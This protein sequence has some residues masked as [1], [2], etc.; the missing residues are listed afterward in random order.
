MNPIKKALQKVKGEVYTDRP[1]L[2]CYST[3]ASIYQIQP[4]AVVCPIK[5]S[6]VS[7]CIAAAKRLMMPVTARAAGTNLAGSCL[8]RGIVLDVSKNMNRIIGVRET[9]RGQFVVE[10]EPGVIINDLQ[11][12]LK[13]KGLFLPHDPSSSEICMIGGN[14][15]TKASGAR[16]VKYG[17]IDDYIESVEF[18]TAEGEIIDTASEDTIPDRIR[19]GISELLERLLAD[20]ATIARLESKRAVKT[21]SGYNMRALLD[22][23]DH[24]RIGC[25]IA[26]LMSGSV[27]TLGIFTRI[28]LK[29]LPIVSGT[30]IS[31][32]YFKSLSDAGDAVQHIRKLGPV[33]IEM[34][35]ATSLGIVRG[36]YPDLEIPEDASALFVEFEGD[37][38][39]S[40]I[41]DLEWMIHERYDVHWI[42][43][44][45]DDQELQEGIWAVRK[46]LVPILTNYDEKIKPDAFIDD[47]AVAIPDLAPLI[48]DLHEI[49]DHYHIAAAIYGHA[50]SGNLHIRPML[51][52]NDPANIKL[53]PELADRVYEAVFKY[54]GT[55]TGE[56]G[57]G[58][59]RTMFLEK[60]WGSEIYG[61]MRE[62]KEI[63]DPNDILNPD[64]IFSERTITEDIK[65]PTKYINKFEARC[66]NCGYCKSVCPIATTK[67]GE[68]GSRSFLQLA[69]FRNFEDPAPG[70]SRRAEKMLRTCLGC[71]R[72]MTRC[73]SH[74]SI[75]E[76]LFS[77]KSPP[78]YTKKAMSMW[79]SDYDRF[80]K[81]A[82]FFGRLMSPA[83]GAALGRDLPKVRK[84]PR[85]FVDRA[86]KQKSGAMTSV[87][88]VAVFEG[89]ASAILDDNVFESMVRVLEESGFDV[90][91]PDQCCCGL[92]MIGEGLYDLARDAARKNVAA[93]SDA[94]YDA[95]VTACASCT[96]ML[97]QFG[98]LLGD[99]SAKKVSSIT[100]DIGEFLEKFTDDRAFSKEKLEMRVA[101]HHP[102][103]LA[104]AGVADADSCAILKRIVTD[105]V[106]LPDGCCGGAGAYGILH[107]D[108]SERIFDRKAE[109]I[110]EI[111]P[112]T[113]VTTCPSCELQFRHN[114]AKRGITCEVRNIVEVV[115][116]YYSGGKR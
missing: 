46:A 116:R 110:L 62:I 32:I 77:Q 29:V 52:L 76:L 82:R 91:I 106:E 6:D 100:Y 88:T 34:M 73:P 64:V 1:T 98:N 20:A 55:M 78:I 42:F 36:E 99:D 31:A 33:K 9:D 97:K 72:C 81:Y 108:L 17:T 94:R 63:F 107:S 71:L 74:A 68:T 59:L 25:M 13:A 16:A 47:V 102:C 84:S 11:A 85:A 113:I 28:R 26:H 39:K 70:E 89:C 53:L 104:A 3:D 5:A 21:A 18:V 10:V 8:G 111:D 105:F 51:N 2:Y 50:G 19:T 112:D 96:M 24:D 87:M 15:G 40:K 67:K 83:V 48:G 30:A 86:Q 90:V 27:G 35:D 44:E 66:I 7:E 103:H 54:N 101:Y 79:A 45:S 75:G 69:R 95:I 12:Y 109:A 49:F 4:A 43:S 58:R 37:S 56:H 22:Y 57:M 23:D 80:E 61:Y 65:Y 38:R 114:L 14:L 115:D 93:F 92:P 60:E 41:R